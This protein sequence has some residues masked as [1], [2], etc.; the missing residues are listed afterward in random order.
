MPPPVVTV[1]TVGRT[2]SGPLRELRHDYATRIGRMA[3]VVVGQVRPSRARSPIVRRREETTALVREL[4]KRGRVVALDAR[5][6]SLDSEAF[7]GQ[8]ERWS[9]GDGVTFLVG[10]PD[11]LDDHVLRCVLGDGFDR[12]SLGPM[13]LPH[14]LALVVL[15]EQ[16]YRALAA[17]RNHP[18]SR[19]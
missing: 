14:E 6:K 8:L 7:R 10:G 19:H 4:P 18:Y 11:G 2:G 15:L 16:I 5:G 12:L 3:T 9:A 1:V 13:T 17:G